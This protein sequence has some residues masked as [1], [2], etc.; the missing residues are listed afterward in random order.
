VPAA[1]STVTAVDAYDAAAVM[2]AWIVEQG[3]SES[4]QPAVGA[5]LV[6]LT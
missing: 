3:L 6:L 5:L 1:T 2:P 4:A